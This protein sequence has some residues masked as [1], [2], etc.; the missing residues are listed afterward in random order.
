[1]G[2]WEQLRLM[3]VSGLGIGG[4]ARIFNLLMRI[5][6]ICLIRGRSLVNYI[7]FTFFMAIVLFNFFI[8][9]VQSKL[10]LFKVP[11]HFRQFYLNFTTP[12]KATTLQRLTIEL[13]RRH[14]YPS[15]NYFRLPQRDMSNFMILPRHFLYIFAADQKYLIHV[16]PH[17]LHSTLHSL[18]F[19]YL[20]F[21][22]FSLFRCFPLAPQFFFF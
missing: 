21:L 8:L 7:L 15:Q 11:T 18:I 19:F 14:Y 12:F 4:I 22:F 13:C 20:S 9:W 5:H 10:T 17:P 3:A 1:M 16:Y 6:F 2:G